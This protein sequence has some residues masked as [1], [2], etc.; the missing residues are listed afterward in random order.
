MADETTI[1]EQSGIKVTNL[2]AVFGEKT[3]AVSNITAVETQSQEPSAFLPTILFLGGALLLILFGASIFDSGSQNAALNGGIKWN[4]LLG[5]VLMLVVGI[6]IMRSAKTMYTV[7][8]SSASGE[9][10]AYSSTDEAQIRAIVEA[11][12]EA[13]IQKG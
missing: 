1:Y 8:V 5:G 10:R 2:R 12:N 11:I 9:I 6:S 13:I 4:D 7:K 3:Y